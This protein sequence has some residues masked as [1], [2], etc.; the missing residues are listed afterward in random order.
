MR[1]IAPISV[2]VRT[3][4][5]AMGVGEI[6]AIVGTILAAIGSLL[7]TLGPLLSKSN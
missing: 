2:A 3:P 1:H 4:A 6:M 7:V 5:P